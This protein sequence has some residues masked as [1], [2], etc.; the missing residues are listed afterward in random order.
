MVNNRFNFKE[1]RKK[2]KKMKKAKIFIALFCCLLCFVFVCYFKLLKINGKNIY[3]YIYNFFHIYVNFFFQFFSY[4]P[5][6]NITKFRNN[7]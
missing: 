2:K 1:K 3:V 4:F 5:F 7:F 6:L